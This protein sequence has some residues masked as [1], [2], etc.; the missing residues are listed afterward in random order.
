MRILLSVPQSSPE[1]SSHVVL[2]GVP[3]QTITMSDREGG[4]L[5]LLQAVAPT[6]FVEPYISIM[7]THCILFLFSLSLFIYVSQTHLILMNCISV[8]MQLRTPTHIFVFLCSLYHACTCACMCVVT[9][10]YVVYECM[11][12]HAFIHVFVPGCFVSIYVVMDVSSLSMLGEASTLSQSITNS[13]PFI[14]IHAN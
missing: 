3:W 5:R 8:H 4:W 2:Q 9:S 11:R 10:F 7:F 13:F 6:F 14:I 1:K 12:K